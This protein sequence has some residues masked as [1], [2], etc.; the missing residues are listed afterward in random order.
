MVDE[1][2]DSIAAWWVE[3]VDH[4]P[5]DSTDLLDLLDELVIDTGG[6][7]ID[8]GCGEGQV[9]R[10]LGPP[11][12]GT[13]ISARLLERAGRSGPTVL[14]RLPDLG[15]VRPRSFDRAVCVGAMEMV[16]DHRRL[17]HEIAAAVRPGGHLVVVMNHPVS[18]SP[19]SEPLVDPTGEILWRWG[20]YLS[21]GHLV[22]IVE[23]Q[24]IVLFHRTLGELLSA[25]AEAGWR[26]DR[27][28][29]RGPSAETVTRF[30]EYRGQ[31]HIP[32]VLGCRWSRDA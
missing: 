22:Q 27:V 3:T 26:L 25:A 28:V 31:E 23:E 29:E 2:W 18:T 20:E 4:D 14:A 10:H 5:R 1:P 7:T 21:P 16:H 19:T 32:T 24:Q 15:W 6:T 12:I 17:L 8:L 11:I 13:D 9:M 30:P